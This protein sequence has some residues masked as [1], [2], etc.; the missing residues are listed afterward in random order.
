[1]GVKAMVQRQGMNLNI[2]ELHL[3]SLSG[4]S[5]DRLH[6]EIERELTQMLQAEGMPGALNQRDNAYSVT[7][8]HLTSD[9]NAL[10]PAD[11][12][13]HIAQHLYQNWQKRHD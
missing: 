9:I 7:T 3:P 6:G 4:I 5:I 8:P 11:I 1:M 2:E 13:K 10:P 12:A